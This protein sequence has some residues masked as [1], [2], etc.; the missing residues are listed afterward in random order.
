MAK[1]APCPADPAVPKRKRLGDSEL[2]PT[3]I[4]RAADGGVD[5]AGLDR[6]RTAADR[7][8]VAV[9]AGIDGVH[10]DGTDPGT[11]DQQRLAA[12]NRDR[13][14]LPGNLVRQGQVAVLELNHRGRRRESLPATRG[15]GFHVKLTVEQQQ[16]PSRQERQLAV[17][18]QRIQQ[19]MRLRLDGRA[20]EHH[21]AG[22]Q[23]HRPVLHGDHAV[24]FRDESRGSGDVQRAVTGQ[25]HRLGLVPQ[26][27][28]ALIVHL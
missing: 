9:H 19:P 3:G 10:P 2:G 17:A 25:E 18:A 15:H 22:G 24:F 1:R 20:V 14:R 8:V 12:K 7:D 21:P 16:L 23:F 11:F 27:N 6:H 5:D 28:V 4:A 26:V 13:P